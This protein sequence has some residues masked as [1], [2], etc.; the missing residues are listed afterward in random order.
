MELSH[1]SVLIT[2]AGSGIGRA[3]AV[4]LARYGTRQVL[5][6]RR[7]H[8]L[9]ETAV[10][11]R[12][13]G[14]EAETV[15][16]DIT[17]DAVRAQAL[18]TAVETHGG[19]DILV[20]NAGCLAAGRLERM[21]VEDI[22][23][24]IDV[25]LIAPILLTRDAIPLLRRSDDAVIINMSSAVALIAIAFYSPYV[26]CKAGMALFSESLRR[27]LYGEGIHVM[28]VYP[29]ATRTPMMDTTTAGPELG[30]D[31]E[32]PEAVAEAIIAGLREDA[33]EVVRD[34]DRRAAM[35]E[36]NRNRPAE[37]DARISRKKHLLEAA[38]ANHR[39]M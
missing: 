10:C 17:D 14:G 27:E 21:S 5:V 38:V 28:A 12:D 3:L 31:Y 11:V 36:A 32:P 18:Q 29:N 15:M 20:N 1:R 19:L 26:A 24:Q 35:L 37:V 16:G 9:M 6:G 23:R 8:L 34:A 30:F 25:D 4:S 7:D 22:R 2:G 13:A 33:V 39:S